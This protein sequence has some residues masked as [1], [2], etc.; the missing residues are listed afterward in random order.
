MT[1]VH[2]LPAEQLGRARAARAASRHLHA[3]VD[4]APA[5]YTTV[6]SDA[7]VLL[8]TLEADDVVARPTGLGGLWFGLCV[9]VSVVVL[10]A[11][12]AIVGFG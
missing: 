5:A 1:D 3:I 9:V 4:E 8:A 6:E 7:P 11:Y 2:P 12:D 10:V